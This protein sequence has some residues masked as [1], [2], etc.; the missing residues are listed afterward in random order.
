MQDLLVVFLAIGVWLAFGVVI[1][2][3]FVKLQ[4]TER[5]TRFPEEN[6]E[7]PE[8]N[9]VGRGGMDGAR[10]VRRPFAR[11]TLYS[12]F[13]VAS[14][15]TQRRM[16]PY[17]AITKLEPYDRRGQQWLLINATQPDTGRE[18]E[19]YFLNADIDAVQKAIEEKR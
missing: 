9:F 4:I 7:E 13:F 5:D 2:I 6:T 12:D 16:F 8:C 15:K 19:M 18:F 3:G 10:P 1:Y 17:S 11:L 14:F